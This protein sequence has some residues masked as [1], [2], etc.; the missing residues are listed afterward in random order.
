M[1]V[2]GFTEIVLVLLSVFHVYVAA[3]VTVSIVEAPAQIVAEFTATVGK[4]F[5]TIAVV[6]L[7]VQPKFDPVTV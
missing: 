7:L 4:L 6:L 3:P 5:T 1:L 2:I